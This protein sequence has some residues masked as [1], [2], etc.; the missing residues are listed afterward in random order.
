MPLI[1]GPLVA[2]IIVMEHVSVYRF[3]PQSF[4]PMKSSIKSLGTRQHRARNHTYK[5]AFTSS[6]L[7]GILVQIEAGEATIHS[8]IALGIGMAV[9]CVAGV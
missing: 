9:A 5:L 4:A 1:T 2:E 7:R 3:R 6:C 8:G